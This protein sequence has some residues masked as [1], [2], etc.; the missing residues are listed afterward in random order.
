MNPDLAFA[1]G[2]HENHLRAINTIRGLGEFPLLCG[3][4]S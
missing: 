1:R 2:G 4:K 3:K